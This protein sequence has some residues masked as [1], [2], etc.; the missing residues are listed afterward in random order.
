MTIFIAYGLQPIQAC[1]KPNVL[2]VGLRG[3]D[4]KPRMYLVSSFPLHPTYR[5]CAVFYRVCSEFER[6]HYPVRAG[7]CQPLRLST[8]T[9]TLPKSRYVGWVKGGI[10]MSADQ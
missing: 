1:P 10:R 6:P 2:N 7:S 5:A 4:N 3:W 9:Q 8:L